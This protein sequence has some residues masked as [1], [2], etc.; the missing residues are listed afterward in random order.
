V[1]STQTVSSFH[2]GIYLVWTI[3]GDVQ[4]NVTLTGG[5]NAV[6]SGVFFK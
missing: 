3:S 1:L 5:A 4:I 2:G 6:I